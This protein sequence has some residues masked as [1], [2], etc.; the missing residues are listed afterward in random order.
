MTKWRV[1]ATAALLSLGGAAM[2]QGPEQAV[3]EQLARQGYVEFEVSRTLLGRIRVV[4]FAPGG[5]RRE[6]V[7]NPATGEILRDLLQGGAAVPRVLDRSDGPD[8]PAPEEAV[9]SDA[10]SDGSG[11]EAADAGDDGGAAPAAAEEPAPDEDAAPDQ[12]AEPTEPAEEPEDEVPGRDD[13]KNKDRD[14]GDEG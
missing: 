1:W 11:E 3:I 12:E 2:S 6:I 8:R 13:R 10:E 9:V 4:A 14:G 7:F 5:E